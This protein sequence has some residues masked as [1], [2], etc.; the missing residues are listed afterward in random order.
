MTCAAVD[1]HNSGKLVMLQ[2]D[3]EKCLL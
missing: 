1:R 3:L 2:L